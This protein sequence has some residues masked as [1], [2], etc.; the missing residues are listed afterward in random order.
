MAWYNSP[1]GKCVGAFIVLAGIGIAGTGIG[2]CQYLSNI[3]T[4]QNLPQ[5]QEMR[6][7]GHDIKF[8]TLENSMAVTEVDKE[9]ILDFVKRRDLAE[10]K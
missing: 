1:V 10:K 8:Y 3:S 5:S 4:P 7:D 2:S 9:P 6:V